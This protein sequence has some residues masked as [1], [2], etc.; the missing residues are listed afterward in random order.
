MMAPGLL[1]ATLLW[2][3]AGCQPL[4]AGESH[5]HCTTEHPTIIHDDVLD[6]DL[7]KNHQYG[8]IGWWCWSLLLLL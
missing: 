6:H 5:H 3:S 8:S 7:A 1:L 4:A 2:R